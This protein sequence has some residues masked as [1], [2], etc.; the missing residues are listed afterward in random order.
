MKL[1]NRGAR[2]YLNLTHQKGS[3]LCS[4]KS[5]EISNKATKITSSL[6]SFLEKMLSDTHSLPHNSTHY[7]MV[8]IFS[9]FFSTHSQKS[10]VDAVRS[11]ALAGPRVHIK[12][13]LE[14]F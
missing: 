11:S 5:P 6:S 8:L 13:V 4:S 2:H 1:R 7:V 14:I 12:P 9:V 10:P 3:L